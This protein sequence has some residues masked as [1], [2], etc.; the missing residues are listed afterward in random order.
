MTSPPTS[1]PSPPRTWIR[2]LHVTGGGYLPNLDLHFSPRGNVICGGPGAGKSTALE[3]LRYVLMLPIPPERRAEKEKLIAT[4]LGSGRAHVEYET[5]DGVVYVLSRAGGEP[6]PRIDAPRS[7]QGMDAVRLIESTLPVR[8]AGH[9][10]LER[11]ATD[12][13]ARLDLIARFVWN[14]WEAVGA[15]VTRARRALNENGAVLVRVEGEIAALAK[16]CAPLATQRARLEELRKEAGGDPEPLDAAHHRRAVRERER[17]MIVAAKQETDSLANELG[18]LAREARRRL[19]HVVDAEALAGPNAD[20]LADVAAHVQHIT[21]TLDEA[22]A[23]VLAVHAGGAPLVAER[24]RALA[25]RHDVED[26][27][28]RALVAAH[29]SNTGRA[30]E[31]LTLDKNVGELSRAETELA[32]R[33][34]ERTHLL[35]E[36]DALRAKYRAVLRERR[37]LLARAGKEIEEASD[38]HLEIDVEPEAERGAWRALLGELAKGRRFEADDLVKV[39]NGIGPDD[40]CAQVLRGDASVL[41]G[42]LESKA[43]AMRLVSVLLEHPRRY[44]LET[45]DL[46]DVPVIKLLHGETYKPSSELSSGQ[47][48]VAF[49]SIL[50]LDKRGPLIAD[51]PEDNVANRY[52]ADYLCGVFAEVQ[53]DAQLLFVT[54]NGNIPILGC[55]DRV[56]EFDSDGK[57]GWVAAE[58]DT[59]AVQEPMENNFEGGRRAFVKRKAFY[60]V[61]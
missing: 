53:E 42:V 55:M 52:L 46:P 43:V 11:M 15:E 33:K 2:R 30:F 29:D 19:G 5:A 32:S 25:D 23:R 9:G 35:T 41:E 10:E 3:L 34:V 36:R 18:A 39:A 26:D 4:N 16:T 1:L 58:G 60:G 47:R 28:Y 8:F 40:L 22:V 17:L 7:A 57:H 54:H 14:E 6:G 45:G 44:E 48:T 38:K 37:A 31:R 21:G 20:L 56:F 13:L 24:A 61:E 50:L 49:A 12:G 51:Q 59:R 27:A